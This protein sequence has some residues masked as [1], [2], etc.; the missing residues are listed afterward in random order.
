MARQI[1]AFRE[2]IEVTVDGK[3]GLG[4]LS[5]VEQKL[6]SFTH[7]FSGALGVV[8]KEG[9]EG[10]HKVQGLGSA[11]SGLVGPASIAVGAMSAVG[12]SIFGAGAAIFALVEKAS[13]FGSQIHDLA[14]QTGLGAETISSLKFA[15]DQSSGSIEEFSKGMKKF[16]LTVA[17]AARGSEEAE[18]KLTRLGVDPKAAVLDLD[19]A[20]GQALR[21]IAKAPPG[22]LQT[23]RAADAF[24]SKLGASL[25]PTIL[26]FDGNLD[27]LI[28]QV[29]K[30][31]GTLSDAEADELDKFGDMLDTVKAQAAGMANQFALGVAP[32]ITRAMGDI[33]RSAM[34]NA[35][36]MKQW[37]DDVGAAMRGARKFGESEL[38]QLLFFVSELSVKTNLLVLAFKGLKSLGGGSE[39]GG[40]TGEDVYGPGGT[41]RGG[42][43]NLPGTAE[44]KAEAARRA[45]LAGM[46]QDA[47]E[48]AA[49]SAK[50]TT[51]PLS[52]F[53]RIAESTGLSVRFFGKETE[54][55]RVEQSLLA[56]D[57]DKVNP[58]LKEQALLYADIAIKNAQMLDVLKGEADREAKIKKELVAATEALTGFQER[59][60]ERVRQAKYGAKTHLDL[61]NDEIGALLKL[62]SVVTRA[63]ELRNPRLGHAALTPDPHP[64]VEVKTNDLIAARFGAIAQD[65]KEDADTLVNEALLP[66]ADAFGELGAAANDFEL[67]MSD[68]GRRLEEALGPPPAEKLDQWKSAFAGLKDA[69]MD[70]FHQLGQGLGDMLG[71]WV[72]LGDQ[73]ELSMG[74]MVASVLAGVAAQSLVL[75]IFETAKGFAS[76]FWNPAEAAAHFHAAAMFGILAAGGAGLGR[77]AAGDKF[78][79]KEP[80]PRAMGGP[81]RRGMS[82]IVGE[83]RPEL[84]VPNS[85][86]YVHPRVGGGSGGGDAMM[87]RLLAALDRSNAATERQNAFLGRMENWRPHDVVKMGA[88]GLIDAYD[89]DA[90]LIELSSRRHRLP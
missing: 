44:F 51:D 75:A 81:V 72:I 27:Q 23:E 3:Q 83:R 80:E 55:A 17:E 69:G 65:F 12:A 18:K 64:R 1:T 26:S 8:S 85:D 39:D 77:L 15:A 89:Q 53:K 46:E 33:S 58:K 84:F 10:I 59:Q 74:K 9:G 71:S 38:G 66:M 56:A 5:L 82:Y 14:Q 42:R 61:I 11:I 32:E 4:T 13:E 43:K 34:G 16:S 22:I 68:I 90:G 40:G 54:Q 79:D 88:R 86:G 63:N 47:R 37:G 76:L 31:G 28:S 78:K 52:S 70:A 87:A 35:S 45:G 50:A 21:S 73:A 24:G 29:K 67:Q 62:N 36:V 20:L 48:K 60:E 7:S 41:M 19:K 2:K 57:L 6:K 30:L 25:I 49:K